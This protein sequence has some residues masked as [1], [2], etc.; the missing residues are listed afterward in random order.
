M[1]KEENLFTGP[2]GE[3]YHILELMCPNAAR[4]PRMAA[5][6]IAAWRP[7]EPLRGLEIGCGTGISTLPYLAAREDLRLT[8]VDSSPAMLAQAR[9]NLAEYLAAGRIEFVE[10]GALEFLRGLESGSLDLVVSN[11]AIHNFLEDYRRLVLAEVFRVLKPQGLFLNG[12]RYAIDGRAAHLALTQETVRHWF[13]TFNELKRL[14][15]L[16]DWVVHFFSDESEEHIMW[17]TPALEG[18]KTLGFS[19][20][21]VRF[22]DGVDTLLTAVRP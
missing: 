5:E 22:R 19:D 2:I 10:T 8:A 21:T 6:F 9:A 17:L 4:L 20:V 12:D 11:Y 15:L 16:Q 13:K 18:M 14:D 7:G 3:E 1:T